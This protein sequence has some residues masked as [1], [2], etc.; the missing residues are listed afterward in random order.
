MDSVETE[1]SNSQ[2]RVTNSEAI[3]QLLVR[4]HLLMVADARLPRQ[5]DW[6]S[7]ALSH[8]A[9]PSEDPGSD[10]KSPIALSSLARADERWTCPFRNTSFLSRDIS[11]LLSC[12]TSRDPNNAWSTIRDIRSWVGASSNDGPSFSPSGTA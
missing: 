5:L 1:W 9:Y 3:P 10:G 7:F 2:H 4:R 12:L 11:I 6:L 8:Q